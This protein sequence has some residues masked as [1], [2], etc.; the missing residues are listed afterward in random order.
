MNITQNY[1]EKNDIWQKL[2]LI[3]HSHRSCLGFALAIEVLSVLA[4]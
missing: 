4:T 1:I 2:R 3:T